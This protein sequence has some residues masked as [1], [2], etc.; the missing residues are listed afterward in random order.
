MCT[1]SIHFANGFFFNLKMMHT[2][3]CLQMKHLFFNSFK[4]QNDAVN[5]AK[6]KKNRS[7]TVKSANFIMIYNDSRSR[8]GK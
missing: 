8:I 4:Q 5:F 7:N 2:I 3:G 6:K 1:W